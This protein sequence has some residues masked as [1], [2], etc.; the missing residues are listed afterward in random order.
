MQI[1][2]KKHVNTEIHN[3]TLPDKKTQGKKNYA[4]T[5]NLAY[6]EDLKRKTR[7]LI[8]FGASSPSM[9]L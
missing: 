7:P 5:K 4:L 3:K 9:S 8:T 1:S 6:K 2:R